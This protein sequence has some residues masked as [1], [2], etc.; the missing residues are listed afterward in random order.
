VAAITGGASGI[1]LATAERFLA[2]GARVVI[3]DLNAANGEA[4]LASLSSGGQG[5]R[6]RF[7]RVDVAVEAEVEAL[8]ARTARDFGR[9][10][11]L[12]NNAGVG[13]AF[14]ALTDIHVDDWDYTF[15][16]LVRGVFLGLKHGARRMLG[17]GG[18]GS[19][20]NTAS[21][22]SFSGGA[23]P[24]AYS[25][26]KAAVLNL[27]KA[28]ALELA[29]SRIRVNAICPGPVLTPLMHEGRPDRATA[30]MKDVLPWPD[31]GHPREIAAA[32]LFYAS[33]D[34]SFI[35]GDAMVADGG[36]LAS[37]PGIFG[38]TQFAAIRPGVSGANRGSTGE[39]PVIRKAPSP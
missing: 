10:D 12:F 19:I 28:A 29:P 11:I 17:Q 27:T 14:G 6:V 26:A 7:L 5:G 32:A 33:D 25:S 24:L 36:L 23:G 38:R 16:V 34:A 1:G 21:V 37:G 15:A 22:A 18:G 39:G 9:L 30:L 8:I 4:A 13:G 35:T 3:A 20:I 31:I 2:E